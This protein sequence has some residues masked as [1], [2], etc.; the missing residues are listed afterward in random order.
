MATQKANTSG[1]KGHA[2][3]LYLGLL[4]L[5]SLPFLPLWGPR[6]VPSTV[7]SHQQQDDVSQLDD[8]VLSQNTTL[9][10]RDEY[11]CGPS[12]PCKNGACCGESGYCGYGPTY[13][14]KGCVSN[15]GAVAECGKYAKESG[16]KCPLNT[17]CSEFGYVYISFPFH[18]HLANCY[19]AVR[20]RS[21]VGVSSLR[22]SSDS[23]I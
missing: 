1:S 2:L 16:K 11:N 17:C 19:S 18:N 8:A 15:C 3:S 7:I 21:S 12:N 13:C 10:R 20:P 6:K 9:V 4:V 14:G 23:L 22:R 5:I